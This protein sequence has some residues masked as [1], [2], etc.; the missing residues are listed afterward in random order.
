MV[1][2]VTKRNS[3]V[4]RKSALASGVALLMAMP[5]TGVLPANA[6]SPASPPTV[7][8]AAPAAVQTPGP[9]DRFENRRPIGREGLVLV[10]SRGQLDPQVGRIPKV[11][12]RRVNLQ[13]EFDFELGRLKTVNPPVVTSTSVAATLAKSSTS[14]YRSKAVEADLDLIKYPDDVWRPSLEPGLAQAGTGIG[15]TGPSSFCVSWSR[16]SYNGSHELNGF[17]QT[18]QVGLPGSFPGAL[19][20][21]AL[22]TGRFGSDGSPSLIVSFVEA[23]TGDVKVAHIGVQRDGNG[24]VT[25]LAVTGPVMNLGAVYS[26]NGPATSPSLAVADFA[27][28]GSDQVAVVWAPSSSTASDRHYKAALMEVDGQGHLQQIV[29]PQT[30]T[31]SLPDLPGSGDEQAGPGAAVVRDTS[32]KGPEKARLFVGSGIQGNGKITQLVPSGASFI[33]DDRQLGTMDGATLDTS[34]WRNFHSK[35]ESV[36]DITGDGVDELVS[37]PDWGILNR[38]FGLIDIIDVGTYDNV[39]RTLDSQNALPFVEMTV[40]DTRPTNDQVVAPVPGRPS[41]ASF[42]QIAIAG[43]T[44]DGCS[45]DQRAFFNFA[46]LNAQGKMTFGTPRFISDCGAPDTPELASLAL[47]GRAELGE[48]VPGQYTTLEPSVI[49][50]A[51]PTHF[52]VLDGR[53]YDPNF[54]YAGN[55]YLVPPVCFFT[56]EYEKKTE[57]STEVTSESTEDWAVSAKANAEFSLFDVVDVEAEIR[58]GYGEKFKNIDFTTAKDTIEVNVKARNTDKIYAIRRAYDTLEYPVYQ[59]GGTEPSAYVLTTTPHTITK[60]WIDIN[61]PDAV[62]LNVNHQPGNILSYPEDLSDK[63]NPFISPT[64]K[65]DQSPP[66]GAFAQQ[67]FE[68]SDFSDF[69]YTL[70]KEKVTAEEASTEK[71]WNVGGTLKGGGNVAGLVKVSVEVSGDYKN[72]NLSNTKTSVGDT[73]KLAAILG[74]IDE[75]FGETAYTVKP[76]AYWDE[77][78]ALVLDYAVS[79]GIAPPGAPKTWWQQKYGKNSDITLKL[80]RLLDY[81]KQAGIS[82]DSARFISPGVQVFRGPC[83]PN[84][85][86]TPTTEYAKPGVPLCLRAQ[87]ENYSLKDQSAGVSVEFYDAD[88]DVG[89]TSIGKVSNL[90]AVPARGSQYAYL[91]WTPDARYAG[92]APRFFAKVDSDDVAEEVHEDNNKGYRSHRMVAD[93]TIAPRAPE[94]VEVELSPGRTLDVQWADPLQ[95]VQPNGHEWRV[96]AYPEDGSTP[97]EVVVPE[98]QTTASFADVAPGRYRVAVFSTA[99]GAQSPASHPSEPIDV[100]T[101]APS[102]PSNVVGTAGDRAVGLQWD[103]PAASGGAPIDSY[104]IREFRAP[105][106]TFPEA[107]IDTTVTGSTTAMTLSGLTNGRPYR[108]TV[109]AI[110]GAAP[111]EQSSPSA[112]VTPLG[113]P[114]K[115]TNVKAT[116]GGPGAAEVSWNPPAPSPARADVTSYEVTVSPGGAVS[117]FPGDATTAT[118]SGL[119]T[120]VTYTFTVRPISATGR[121]PESDESNPLT[122]PDAPSAPRNVRAVAGAL[123]GTA[124]VTWIPPANNGGVPMDSYRV[125]LLGGVCQDESGASQQSV[126]SGLA[127]GTPL[128]FTVTGRNEAGLDS[129]PATSPEVSLASAPDIAILRGPKE[130]SY[131]TPEATIEFATSIDGAEVTCFIDGVGQPC[132]SPLRLTA[133]ADG[134]HTFRAKA[135]GPGGSAS[136]PLLS[137]FVDSQD[138]KATV[139]D[140][141]AIA[142]KGIPRLRYSGNDR[143]GAGLAAYQIRTRQIGVLGNFEEP[144]VVNDSDAS[145]ERVRRL[146]VDRGKTVCASVRAVDGVGNWSGWSDWSCV[147]R[148]LD[149]SSLKA[150]GRW[151]PVKGRFFSQKKALGAVDYRSALSIRIGRS[152]SVS[153]TAVACSDCGRLEVRHRGQLLKVID[154]SD[155]GAD[156]VGTAAGRHAKEF[157][158]DWPES[159]RGYLRLVSLGGGPVIIDGVT[160]KR[161]K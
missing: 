62:D 72:S 154:L 34:Q 119:Q 118:V 79:P 138:P 101:E 24:R 50:N 41:T 3:A 94:E 65:D 40:L 136:T 32:G 104:R 6:V 112:P 121:G 152:E 73:T 80:P 17:A 55:Q 43:T 153:V 52:D 82:S 92:S 26:G 140:L 141:P 149:Q 116:R 145:P 64:A 28:A 84:D 5:M 120:G 30:V 66:V 11:D 135:E 128:I 25:G 114:E 143:G 99:G 18:Y 12:V 21:V 95:P 8:Q 74:G 22:S 33:V 90:G 157:S 54:C 115:V 7:A 110:N 4:G 122:L 47:D 150:S 13:S 2:G 130:G 44:Q 87:V 37:L 91:D 71:D 46:S 98:G 77:S 38:Q 67:E 133:L 97:L 146:K 156:R 129:P 96:V 76:F 148:P 68:L 60:R 86:R 158:V 100:V 160:V 10:E 134:K 31:P 93:P 109:Q 124:V 57:A 103:P 111:G 1:L 123:P 105:G 23:T 56:S 142:R 147:T 88:P 106:E 127:V 35:I 63:E 51:P 108:F 125:C 132:A 20:E 85:L 139:D 126:F 89:G 78:A 61:S 113:V 48:P 16:P 102:A 42:P 107:L 9:V 36:G 58:G 70:T 29:A 131:T 14:Q 15:C 83:A 49:L 81:E 19:T 27:G 155:A 53:M 151:S 161:R 45:S 117:T 75:S 159:A 69:T 137:W 144:V 59:P 39:F